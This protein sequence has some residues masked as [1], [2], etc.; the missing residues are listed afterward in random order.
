[1]LARSKLKNIEVTTS[2][3]LIDNKISHEE[4]TSAINVERWW[5]LNIRMMKSQ[6]RDTEKYDLIEKGKSI[7]INEITKRKLKSQI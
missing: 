5:K 7:D 4:F 1:M 2:K 3:E 6:R